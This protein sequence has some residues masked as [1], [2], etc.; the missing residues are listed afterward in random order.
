MICCTSILCVPLHLPTLSDL[1][2]QAG[3]FI[4]PHELDASCLLLE[5]AAWAP[6][7][8][9]PFWQ[10]PH[11]HEAHLPSGEPQQASEGFQSEDAEVSSSQEM[12]VAAA[13]EDDHPQDAHDSGDV[14]VEEVVEEGEEA[15]AIDAAVVEVEP[16]FTSADPTLSS[17]AEEHRPKETEEEDA[18][19]H[20]SEQRHSLPPPPEIAFPTTASDGDDGTDQQAGLAML[21]VLREALSDALDAA[22][23][24]PVA[25]AWECLRPGRVPAFAELLE[26]VPGQYAGASKSEDIAL[27]GEQGGELATADPPTKGGDLGASASAVEPVDA[28]LLDYRF[29]A[30]AEFVV[31]SAVIGLVGESAAGD[32]GTT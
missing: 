11:A 13:V 32:W 4:P 27:P 14:S 15:S 23:L 26:D 28:I 6:P 21:A 16:E 17:N 2:I 25:E 19:D 18:D 30:F 5:G 31:E 10:Q 29:Q 3:T 12:R 7:T 22:R 1:Q 9:R 24:S 20:S 8:A